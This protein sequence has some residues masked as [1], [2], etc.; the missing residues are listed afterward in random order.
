MSNPGSGGLLSLMSD[1]VPAL[2]AAD[3]DGAQ[4]FPLYPYDRQERTPVA[5]SKA[6]IPPLAP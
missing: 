2:H 1:L 4:C 5:S 6:S 3:R